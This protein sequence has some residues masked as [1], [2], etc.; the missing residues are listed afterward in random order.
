ARA[1]GG[2]AVSRGRLRKLRGLAA[3]VR[4]YRGR[5]A[6][7]VLTTLLAIGASLAPP[8][9]AG[10]AVDDG[11][12]KGDL[13]AL[14]VIVVVFLVA[15]AVN[16]GASYLETYLVNWVGQRVLQ[17]LRIQIFEHLQRLSIGFYSRNRA[18]VLISRLTNDVEA[19]DQLVTDGVTS[20]VQNTLTLGGSAVI[21]FFLDWRLALA[22]LGILPPLTI[23]TAIFRS[24]SSRA[25]RAVRE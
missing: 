8:Y 24:R 25:Y 14:T 15:A 6:V 19:L 2:G 11:I 17:D 12:R 20:L 10:R 3:L 1:R 21:L 4:P 22:T 7:M 9:L 23:A 13:H 18:G 16:W 5:T